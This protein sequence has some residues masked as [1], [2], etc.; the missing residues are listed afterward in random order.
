MEML[1]TLG[2]ILSLLALAVLGFSKLKRE[3][4][5]PPRQWLRDDGEDEDQQSAT[6]AKQ[7][8]PQYCNGPMQSKYPLD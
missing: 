4:L 3:L 8:P 1:I 5:G 7:S 2:L 6:G